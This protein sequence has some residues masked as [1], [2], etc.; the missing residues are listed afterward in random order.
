MILTNEQLNSWHILYTNQ[1]IALGRK[2]SNFDRRTLA[3]NVSISSEIKSLNFLENQIIYQI[4]NRIHHSINFGE[5]V[6]TATAAVGV[7]FISRILNR[8]TV[9]LIDELFDS[10]ALIHIDKLAN[11][12]LQNLILEKYRQSVTKY[13]TIL[14]F[15]QNSLF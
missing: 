3:R 11:W 13:F 1:H 4:Y 6:C 10:I 15:S 14:R 7:F 12:G 9:K 2:I 5:G 8:V